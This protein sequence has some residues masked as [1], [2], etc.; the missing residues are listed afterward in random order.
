MAIIAYGQSGSGKMYTMGTPNL[1]I[2][3][4]VFRN[5]FDIMD[6]GTSVITVILRGTKKLLKYYPNE[7]P[8]RPKYR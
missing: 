5:I 8:T 2:I 4:H 7:M 6:V 3:L 1:G